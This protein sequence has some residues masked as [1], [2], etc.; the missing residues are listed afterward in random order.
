MNESAEIAKL[1]E[2]NKVLRAQV[3]SFVERIANARMHGQFCHDALVCLLETQ[4]QDTFL[5]SLARRLIDATSCDEVAL[6]QV[7]GKCNRWNRDGALDSVHA[8]GQPCPLVCL[9]VKEE[10]DVLQ[11]FPDLHHDPRLT[12]PPV[13]PTQS[14]LCHRICLDGMFWGLLSLLY[15]KAPHAFRDSDRRILTSATYI[16]SMCV[17][18]EVRDR[19][20]ESEML[21]RS[22][23]IEKTPLSIYIKDADN[24]FRY[25]VVN[26][27]TCQ[28]LGMTRDQL[29]GRND[30][31]VF[32]PEAAVPYLEVDRQAMER[33][34]VT[35]FQQTYV[36][37]SGALRPVASVR[38][39]VTTPDGRRLLIGYS[40]EISEFLE[41]QRKIEELQRRTAEER[42]RAILAEETDAF[43]ARL[44]KTVALFSEDPPSDFVLSEIGKF[45]HADR[46]Y[47]Y[48]FKEPGK[49]GVCENTHEWCAEGVRT[50][51]NGQKS[52]DMAD[53]PEPYGTIMAGRDFA[54]PDVSRLPSRSRAWLEPQGIQ[55]LIITPVKDQQ[56]VIIG[57]VGFDFTTRKVESFDWRIVHA[58]HEAADIL[59][60]CR[61][62]SQFYFAMRA[63]EKSQADFFASISHDIRTPLNS[64]IGFT[65]LLKD[66]KDPAMRADYLE[67]ISFSGNTLLALVN[68]VLD[69]SR[70]DANALTICRESVDFSR[71]LKLVAYTFEPS[72][73][74]KNLELVLDIADM[75]LLMIDEHRARQV[76]FNLLGNAVKYTDAGTISVL[77]RFTPD[78]EGRGELF[79][80]VSDTGIGIAPEDVSKLMRPYVRIQRSRES[81]GGTGLGLLICKRIVDAC[82]GTMSVTS[83][84]GKGS[85]FS[86]SVSGIAYREVTGTERTSAPCVQEACDLSKFCV[87]VVDDLEMNR[88]VLCANCRKLGV[89]RV[90]EAGS[91][92]DALELIDGEVDLVLCDMKMPGM[93]G[94]AFLRVLRARPA[95]ADLPVV[96]VTADVAARKY[97]SGLGAD[98]VLLKPVVQEDL[99][100]TLVCNLHRDT[101]IRR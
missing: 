28:R 10:G 71:M 101:Q 16:I 59:S 2:E 31:E 79:F 46:S 91:G 60:I 17:H 62:R 13:C 38:Y 26:E 89:G 32:S 70:L 72:L 67:R 100:Q 42:D 85:T 77:G 75:P 29:I 74:E 80:S 96:L 63:A 27:F 94:A 98:G 19:F 36:D 33:D 93:D 51:I 84:P 87:L 66:E 54:A 22:Q 43:V 76:F 97:G 52:C 1:K 7:D 34:G 61:S 48:R 45:V 5:D 73:R 47:I 86:V 90:L 68:D 30:T 24:D 44:L 41:K 69:L 88:R 35:N 64:I 83:N 6:L 14:V 58:L 95:F 18:G 82:G 78:G 3:D 23:A 57:F 25:L 81:R 55:S 15:T 92:P 50:Q 8:C 11:E 9:G 40:V 12:V 99:L 49:S 21:L 39:P 20:H 37:S 56:G 53:F 4:G 65:E